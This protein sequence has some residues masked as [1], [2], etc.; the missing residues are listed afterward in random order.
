MVESQK[1]QCFTDE[2][3]SFFTLPTE[4][5]LKVYQFLMNDAD[6]KDTQVQ[7]TREGDKFEIPSKMLKISDRYPD[8]QSLSSQLLRACKTIYDE[9]IPSLYSSR[10]V[11]VE[12]FPSLSD[13]LSR[14]GSRACSFIDTIILDDSA[15][16]TYLAG[17]TRSRSRPY[18][19]VDD[20]WDE[21][22]DFD[23]ARSLPPLP[24]LK[25]VRLHCKD[26]AD[27]FDFPAVKMSL[28]GISLRRFARSRPGKD[29]FVGKAM[30][31]IGDRPDIKWE[32]RLR[33]HLSGAVD[34]IQPERGGNGEF[35]IHV[36][37]RVVT[38]REDGQDSQRWEIE[39]LESGPGP[40]I[41]AYRLVK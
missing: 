8:Y 15:I 38:A 2:A 24:K 19:V 9:A 16:P 23:T 30:A 18:D 25:S 22:N 29:H 31:M 10:T 5:R 3:Y 26:C 12:C 1:A 21:G 32:I 41:C 40:D 7:R 11:I 6:E 13:G 4:L 39:D 14:I 36:G 28:M 20:T 17:P 27:S 37:F 35:C 34:S 33:T